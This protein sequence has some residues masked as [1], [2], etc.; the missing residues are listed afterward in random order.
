M[1]IGSNGKGDW[2]QLAC[3]ELVGILCRKPMG[4]IG[5]ANGNCLQLPLAPIG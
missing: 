4:A 2:G 3:V 1:A 5:L